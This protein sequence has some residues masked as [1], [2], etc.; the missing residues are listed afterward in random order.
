MSMSNRYPRGAFAAPADSPKVRPTPAND[1]VP[2]VRP[3]RPRRPPMPANDN[4]PGWRPS[5]IPGGKKAAAGMLRR[6]LP[7]LI[8]VLGWALTAYEIYDLMQ[9]L[10]D[11]PHPYGSLDPV[12]YTKYGECSGG[13]WPSGPE[14]AWLTVV[15]PCL[16]SGNYNP[17]DPAP[18][19]Y[20]QWGVSELAY[21]WFKLL[22]S[23][24]TW[25]P[26]RERWG[27][28][29]YWQKNPTG[30]YAAPGIVPYILPPFPLWFPW[31]PSI[32][33][34]APPFSPMPQPVPL[35]VRRPGF[36]PAPNP[37]EAYPPRGYQVPQSQEAPGEEPAPVIRARPRR[38]REKEIKVTASNGIRKW[39]GWA[40]SQYS[41]I[42][43]LV[44]ALYEAL[45][46]ELQSKK[47][48][49]WDKVEKLYKYSDQ[50]DMA[51]AMTNIVYDQVTDPKFAEQFQAMQEALAEFGI[52][53]PD[54]YGISGSSGPWSGST[55]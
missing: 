15:R 11:Y 3:P 54:L 34:L 12:G 48:T 29:E 33:P 49:L 40:L 17:P 35:P 52:A 53:L 4:L 31:V 28:K 23:D 44:D 42:G 32:W 46:D 30:P 5:R 38:K 6:M 14:M 43:D 21:R 45:P 7:R 47:D 41:E 13:T 39:L 51:E 1:N 36:E 24:V 2:Q 22:P 18:E 20:V 10:G 55:R 19:Q 25:S 27:A 50:I 37:E 9:R 8:P 16:S 26:F